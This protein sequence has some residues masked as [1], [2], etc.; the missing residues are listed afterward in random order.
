MRFELAHLQADESERFPLAEMEA[1]AWIRL[2]VSD[3]GIGM[4]PTVLDHVFEPFFTTKEPGQ[5]T[6]LG[7]AQVHGIVGQHDGHIIVESEIG[8]GTTF[9]IYLPALAVVSASSPTAH[10]L[11]GNR[12][13][14]RGD[15]PC[16][17]R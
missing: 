10:S 13:G 5:G 2:V 9:T 8:A 3:T 15:S 1:R 16:C 7:L 6:G 11:P 14:E 12:I 4:P 17:G